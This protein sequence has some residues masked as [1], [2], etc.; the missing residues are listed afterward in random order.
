MRFLLFTISLILAALV[1]VYY[2]DL[3]DED[4]RHAI[5]F[6]SENLD[7]QTKQARKHTAAT[8]DAINARLKGLQEEYARIR[9]AVNKESRGGKENL[10]EQTEK[11][12]T[13]TQELQEKIAQLSK[14]A[15][16]RFQE[17]ADYLR[18]Q[19]KALKK[20]VESELGTQRS[21]GKSK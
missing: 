13:A 10:A 20:T 8:I 9:T 18:K 3:T 2:S 6:D 14:E 5:Q 15:G 16:T 12:L 19:V 11:T 1:A 4:I 7:Q 21:D 17:Q